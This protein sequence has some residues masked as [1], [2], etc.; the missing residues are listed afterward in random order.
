MELYSFDRELSMS[1]SHYFMIIER[2]GCDL[3]ASRQGAS[4]CHEG[5]IASRL[6][7]IWDV[8]K[9]SLAIV[10]YWAGLSVA[11]V[12]RPNYSSAKGMDDSL[13]S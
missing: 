6:E 10:S 11:K 1:H 12:L 9:D 7:W 3:Q 13:V 2:L 4:I 5:V 8:S